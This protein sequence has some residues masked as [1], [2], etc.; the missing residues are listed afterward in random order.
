MGR[1][2]CEMFDTMQMRPVRLRIKKLLKEIDAVLA[3]LGRPLLEK[4][5]E[6]P[7]VYGHYLLTDFADCTRIM[8]LLVVANKVTPKEMA[9][10]YGNAQTSE[11]LLYNAH[12][13]NKTLASIAFPTL[14]A[15]DEWMNPPF[16]NFDLMV[17]Q[18]HEVWMRIR[19]EDQIS[20][21]DLTTFQ[22]K[23]R[24]PL[25]LS[26]QLLRAKTT[27]AYDAT[28]KEHQD[29]PEMKPLFKGARIFGEYVLQLLDYDK[30]PWEY[31]DVSGDGQISMTEFCDGARRIGFKGN[32]KK[33]F[34]F[35][36][37]NMSGQIDREEFLTF[38]EAAG[39]PQSQEDLAR[40]A[41]FNE[42]DKMDKKKNQPTKKERKYRKRDA[43]DA[44]LM[45]AGVI[46]FVKL[47]K[48]YE[49]LDAA[50]D[51]F[52]T[53]GGGTITMTEFDEAAV[54]LGLT[55]CAK[56]IFGEIDLNRSGIIDRKEFKE[57]VTDTMKAHDHWMHQGPPIEL[58]IEN[59]L[60]Y[61]KE[62]PSP[63]IFE[64]TMIQGLGDLRFTSAAAERSAMMLEE[65]RRNKELR[66]DDEPTGDII[67]AKAQAALLD[68]AET[69][70]TMQMQSM[71]IPDD[72]LFDG[73]GGNYSMCVA[74]TT[75]VSARV[76]CTDSSEQPVWLET[77]V[78]DRAGEGLPYNQ[79]TVFVL[80]V[81]Q[82]CRSVSRL[83]AQLDVQCIHSIEQLQSAMDSMDLSGDSDVCFTLSASPDANLGGTQLE[84]PLDE[85][86]TLFHEG[87]NDA[88][89]L[90]LIA[91]PSAWRRREA[92]QFFDELRLIVH[93][94]R[95]ARK[96]KQT[97]SA[98]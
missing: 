91:G 72:G 60:T 86:K 46:E 90:H 13:M 88:V 31:F 1:A 81:R 42:M 84:A 14:L 28:R 38:C 20:T 34:G 57:L 22:F 36:D 48:S 24:E 71:A 11:E 27:Q 9:E 30:D 39:Q 52:D 62:W 49:N 15:E 83:V 58:L 19:D 73:T 7:L 75:S 77:A 45:S 5:L 33:I 67:S 80:E 59:P 94:L 54:E 3:P 40:E 16:H 87:N 97:D 21:Y 98:V 10:L 53:H 44:V 76:I 82:R 68:I 55:A 37:R 63:S 2:L 6:D 41:A 17:L 61:N 92:V 65:I 35:I 89:V 43:D 12:V 18:I 74:A 47:V 95:A 79:N 25:S 29:E 64:L 32:V 51:A 93:F 69:D 85:A 50:F 66:E 78:V 26:A 23:D 56:K 70:E 96:K 8:A 4:T